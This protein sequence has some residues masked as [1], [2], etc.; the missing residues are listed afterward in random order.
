MVVDLLEIGQH[1]DVELELIL[2][3]L[4]QRVPI[5]HAIAEFTVL[6]DVVNRYCQATLVVEVVTVVLR[7]GITV[8][9]N[10]FLGTLY[11]NLEGFL[12]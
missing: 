5:D 2:L 6:V 12:W 11:A 4:V 8:G 9:L 10:L 7:R 3:V 1:S